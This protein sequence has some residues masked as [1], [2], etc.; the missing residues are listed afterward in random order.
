M[1]GSRSLITGP[2]VGILLALTGPAAA[3]NVLRY[4]SLNGGAI[5]LDPHSLW[6]PH[7][8]A[9]T[10][11]VYEALLDI[12]SNLAIVPQLAMAWRIVDST[13]WEFELRPN[14]RFHDGAPFTAEDV[15]FS[16]DRARAKASD[17]QTSVANIAAVEAVGDHTVQITTTAPD[18]LLWMRL[19]SVAIMS[20]AWAEKHNVR[21]PT[22]LGTGEETFA[23]RH[24]NGTGPF[25]LEEFEP[26]GRWVVIRNPN[27]WGDAEYAH[28][29]DRIVHTY[30]SDEENLAA[31]LDGEIDLLQQPI[32]S[33]LAQ[34]RRNPNLQLVHRPKLFTAF[35]GFDQASQELRTSN[36][37]GK[38]PF[39]DKR[40]R[41]AMAHAIEF[42][43]VLRPLM[44]E[45]FLPAG[46]LV[47]PGVNG[48]APDLDEPPARD[49]G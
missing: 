26:Q 48:Y 27:W 34:I 2:T 20:E 39:K 11:Q 25:V 40:I 29:I 43:S 8:L 15:V 45:L 19:S 21:V 37:K 10:M 38:N 13:H 3:E 9:A 7:N 24:A 47:A 22:G 41:Q 4:T 18:P 36:I 6:T 1:R 23:S 31:L 16:L 35:F 28:N 17:I 14:V 33:G 46:M 32:Y 49:P 5:T 44:G 30:K 12:D 42:E